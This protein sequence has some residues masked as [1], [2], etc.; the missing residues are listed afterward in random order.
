M[1]CEEY[2]FKM[3]RIR[4]PSPTSTPFSQRRKTF[5]SYTIKTDLSPSSPLPPS[6]VQSLAHTLPPSPIDRVLSAD[7]SLFSNSAEYGTYSPNAR[8]LSKHKRSASQD[9]AS[10]RSF[11]SRPLSIF[12][13]PDVINEAQDHH[14][15]TTTILDKATDELQG[16]HNTWGVQNPE[17]GERLAIVSGLL[18]QLAEDQFESRALQIQ[19]NLIAEIL[20]YENYELVPQAE[21]FANWVSRS[22]SR[23]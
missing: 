10:R 7:H 20:D 5:N 1:S 16:I 11:R 23:A 4:T 22:K 3:P 6:D 17:L 12:Q 15:R 18:K 13:M 21:M 2:G 9:R 14:H 8:F 19:K